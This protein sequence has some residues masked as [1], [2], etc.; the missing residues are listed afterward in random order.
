MHSPVFCSHFD[1]V[2]D[3]DEDY[4]LSRFVNIVSFV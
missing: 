2:L 1:Y 4:V 3:V